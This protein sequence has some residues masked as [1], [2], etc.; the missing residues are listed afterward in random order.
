MANTG[1][2]SYNVNCSALTEHEVTA[3]IAHLKVLKPAVV[4]VM[5]DDKKDDPAGAVERGLRIQRETGAEVI[6]RQYE[7]D[8]LWAFEDADS[9]FIR[10]RIYGQAGLTMYAYNEAQEGEHGSY[11]DLAAKLL[12]IGQL[13]VQHKLRVCL[14]NF[15]VGTPNEKE[16]HRF[17]AVL[18]L[19]AA[20]PQYLRLGLHEYAPHLMNAEFGR[21]VNAWPNVP[22]D[23]RPYLAGRFRWLRD[24]QR[25]RGIGRVPV[26]LSEYGWDTI[27]APAFAAWQQSLPGYSDRAGYHVASRWWQ[28]FTS[29]PQFAV[30]QIRWAVDQIYRP[31]PDVMGVCFYCWGGRGDWLRNFDVKDQ[32]DFQRGLEAIDWRRP[33]TPAYTIKSNGATLTRERVGGVTVNVRALPHTGAAI[34]EPRQLKPGDVVEYYA[35]SEASGSGYAWRRLASGAWF[36][37]VPGQTLEADSEA[38]AVIDA[39]VAIIRDALAVI[40]R[41]AAVLE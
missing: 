4:L 39:Q 12:R 6:H 3:L 23:A 22:A 27:H 21:N 24:Y 30:S 17:D 2:F 18:R 13:C 8:A 38:Q 15:S 40:E 19:I 9:W 41:Y 11:D 26:I 16:W 34:V 1:I 36:A 37:R 25:A 10:H 28:T 31:D 5:N 29:V 7:P 14:A 33:M 20:H 35:D 32:A